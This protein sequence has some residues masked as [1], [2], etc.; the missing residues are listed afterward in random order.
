MLNLILNLYYLT[1]NNI[2]EM[3]NMELLKLMQLLNLL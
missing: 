2:L 3:K 1:N